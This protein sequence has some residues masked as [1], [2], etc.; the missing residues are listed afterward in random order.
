MVPF[1]MVRRGSPPISSIA[2]T[3]KKRCW[4]SIGQKLCSSS[5]LRSP[6]GRGAQRF[7]SRRYR[8]AVCGYRCATPT[9]LLTCCADAS[10]KISCRAKDRRGQ[11]GEFS[12]CADNRR[13]KCPLDHQDSIDMPVDRGPAG[14]PVREARSRKRRV[15]SAVLLTRSPT[16]NYRI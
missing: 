15:I 13:G 3:C 11:K 8:C 2:P 12:I 6:A 10:L 9:D 7:R 4:S 14:N 1:L 5:P 16:A